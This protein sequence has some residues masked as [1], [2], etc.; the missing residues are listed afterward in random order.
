MSRSSPPRVMALLMVRDENDIIAAN[1]RHHAAIGVDAFVIIDHGSIDG[2]YEILEALRRDGFDI[3]LFRRDRDKK[4]DIGEWYATLLDEIRR[5]GGERSLQIDAD[6]FWLPATGNFKTIRWTQPVI[7]A[8]RFNMLAP[9]DALRQPGL[10]LTSHQ[11]RVC[12]PFPAEDYRESVLKD[13]KNFARAYPVLMTAIAPKVA[14]HMSEL[15]QLALAGHAIID[16]D[17]QMLQ[18]PPD[19]EVVVFHY[20][21]RSLEQFQRKIS[22]FSK[23]LAFFPELDKASCWQARYLGDKLAREGLE[24]E[25][26]RYY[27]RAEQLQRYLEEGILVPDPRMARLQAIN[28]SEQMIDAYLNRMIGVQDRTISRLNQKNVVLTRLVHPT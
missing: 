16:E 7:S 9:E 13:D 3:S 11:Y 12:H 23:M 24:Q 4:P 19:G 17:G 25:F 27:P 6:E 2:T 10:V 5:R 22:A 26:R 28:P 15:G 20:P 8:A 18:P 21:I 14:F 1:I